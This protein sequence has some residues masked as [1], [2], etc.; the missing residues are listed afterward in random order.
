MYPAIF[1]GELR[2]NVR[3]GVLA[4]VVHHNYPVHALSEQVADRAADHV[5]LIADHRHRPHAARLDVPTGQLRDSDGALDAALQR[6]PPSHRS[7]KE[8]GQAL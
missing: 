4:E 6:P 8:A 1:A 5:C 7:P 2:Q 3:G